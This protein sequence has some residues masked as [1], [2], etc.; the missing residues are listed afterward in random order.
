[1][2]CPP[3]AFRSPDSAAA[4]DRSV[5]PPWPAAVTRWARTRVSEE[6]YSPSRASA[7]PVC[8][9]MRTRTAPISPQLSRDSARCASSAAPSAS[10]L[11][12]NAEQNASPTI[13]KTWPRCV[14]DGRL[15]QRL[16]AGDGAFRAFGMLLDQA[17]RTFDVGEQEG[18]GAAGE[19]VHTRNGGAGVTVEASIAAPACGDFNRKRSAKQSRGVAHCRVARS[20]GGDGA[21]CYTSD[22]PDDAQRGRAMTIKSINPAT[23]ELLATY[24]EMAP[25]AVSAII[26][27]VH[28]AF[29]QWRRVR[30]AERAGA[31]A[32]GRGDPARGGG[33]ACPPHGTRDGQ[34]G[35]RRHRRSAEMRAR[36]RLLCRQ[37]R[38]LSRPR[39]GR[40]RRRAAASSPSRR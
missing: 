10:P 15:H 26:G 38:T 22:A 17:R 8:K 4:V 7:A 29:L 32:Q 23:G 21:P 39:A 5:C 36:L 2:P 37:R 9:P 14:V 11:W 12:S 24:D 40:D 13:W 25:A 31:D 6:T 27:D 18:D 20:M 33:G 28:A 35:A 1:M 3:A 16:M 30:F 34:T 19:A